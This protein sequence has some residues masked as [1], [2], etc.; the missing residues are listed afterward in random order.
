MDSTEEINWCVFK[1]SLG[2]VFYF[3]EFYLDGLISTHRFM[4]LQFC[5][6]L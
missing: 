5:N 4:V 6:N 2:Y 1:D 3:G